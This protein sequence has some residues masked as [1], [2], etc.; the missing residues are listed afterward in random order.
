[1]STAP[2]TLQIL[3]REHRHCAGENVTYQCTVGGN[4]LTWHT[5]DGQIPQICSSIT[6]H[7]NLNNTYFWTTIVL[8]QGHKLQSTLTFSLLTSMDI[9]CSNETEVEPVSMQALIEGIYTLL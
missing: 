2:T 3:T 7:G 4:A 5:P 1:M 6:C 9:G 8:D